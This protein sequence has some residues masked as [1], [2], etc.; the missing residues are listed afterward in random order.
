MNILLSSRVRW[1]TSFIHGDFPVRK[2]WNGQR[3][4]EKEV[5]S[6]PDCHVF[7]KAFTATHRSTSKSKEAKKKHITNKW[8]GQFHNYTYLKTQNPDFFGDMYGQKTLSTGVHIH[9]CDMFWYGNQDSPLILLIPLKDINTDTLNQNPCRMYWIYSWGFP[10]YQHRGF[11]HQLNPKIPP[12]T[13][14]VLG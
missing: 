5:E 2:L 3:N 8:T 11:M 9:S 13:P 12:L 10:Q 1:F 4:V 7:P 6:L 14:I